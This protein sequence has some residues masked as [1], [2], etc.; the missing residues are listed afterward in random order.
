VFQFKVP[1]SKR[2]LYA[3]RTAFVVFLILVVVVV[4]LKPSIEAVVVLGVTAVVLH[5]LIRRHAARTLYQCPVCRREF[6]VSGSIDFTSPHTPAK[7]LL[8]C[9]ECGEISWCPILD[10][11]RGEASG[12][13]SD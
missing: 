10:S 7:K 8:E 1:S 4:F 3:I 5:L 9:P 6:A 2:K 13:V 11:R 12:R